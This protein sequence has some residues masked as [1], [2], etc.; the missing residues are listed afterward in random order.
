MAFYQIK[1][2]G[3][4]G[5]IADIAPTDLPPNGFTDAINAR[6]TN[7]KVTKI[8]GNKLISFQ[9]E[10]QTVVPLSI[11][12]MPFD[13][14]S[15]G[16]PFNIIGTSEGLYKLDDQHWERLSR[17]IK[18]GNATSASKDIKV[19]PRLLGLSFASN[20]VTVKQGQ[21]VTL[22]ASPVPADV[23][24]ATVKWSA[25]NQSFGTLTV[26][27]D[28]NFQA[29]FAA[30]Q[31]LG[32]VTIYIMSDDELYSDYVAL[33][34]VQNVDKMSMNKE[35]ATII[36]N[37]TET[38]TVTMNPPV[39]PLP[40]L[41]W[42]SSDT[43]VATVVVN[44]SN[45]LQATV[46]THRIGGCVISCFITDSPST[47]ATCNVTVKSGVDYIVLDHYAFTTTQNVTTDKIIATIVPSTAPNKKVTWTVPTGG[48]LVT[49]TPSTDTLTASLTYSGQGVVTVRATAQDGGVAIAECTITINATPPAPR[50]NDYIEDSIDMQVLSLDLAS[51]AAPALLAVT[52]VEIIADTTELDVTQSTTL[53]AKVLPTPTPSDHLIYQW[54]ITTNGIVTHGVSNEDEYTIQG[55]NPGNVTVN[56]SVWS[57]VQEGY[58]VTPANTWWNS[59]VANCAV[60]NI[61]THTPMVKEFNSESFIT[62]PGWGDQTLVDQDGN[63]YIQNFTWTCERVRAFNNRLFALNM[64]EKAQSGIDT[65]YPLRIRWSNFAT[66]NHAPTLWDD[67]A[68]LRDPED[69]NDAEGTLKALINGYAGYIDLADSNGNLIDML[70][71]KD[72]LFIYTEFETYMGTP[73]MNAY[74]PMTFKKLFNDS[75]ILAPG[76]VVEM[77]MGHFVVTQNDILLHNGASKKSIAA[78]RVRNKIIQEIMSVNP[79]ATRVHLHQ[80][81]NEVWIIYVAPGSVKNSW[82]CNKAAIWNFEFDTWTFADIPSAY[83][84]S[85]IDPPT[86]DK[87]AIWSDFAAGGKKPMKWNSPEAAKTRW[88]NNFSN[89]HKR[90]TVVGSE[91]R[92]LWQVDEGSLHH[93]WVASKTDATQFNIVESPLKMVLT[94]QGIDF[95]N[96][97]NDWNQKHINTFHPQ[98]GGTGTLSFVAGGSQYTN[99]MGHQHSYRP[100]IVGKSRN[101][102]VRLNHPYLYYQ[103]VDED[104]TSKASINGMTIDFEIGGRR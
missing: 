12:P 22:T 62:L 4:L 80:D 93:A 74:Q 28:N 70:P 102:S 52:S 79:L 37:Q 42:V 81:K 87:S 71:L 26:D 68:D 100:F 56:L 14:F 104:I 46:T 17:W 43:T 91:M 31:T 82:Y 97:T 101:V 54:T 2:L 9:D 50:Q 72:Y 65:H 5:V 25:S 51:P 39:T 8:G 60:A 30:G 20:S 96:I 10:D 57:A 36:T 53:K 67:F 69:N 95:D 32:D 94:R 75:G 24:N 29:T 15:A 1:N 45:H 55:M 86:L 3:E 58:T 6:F 92:G 7:G 19:F 83:C 16:L 98:V 23:R 76:C 90:I 27:P 44:P 21:T 66:E 49:V 88:Q 103:I 78:S 35:T 89:F 48:N 11:L 38:F 59:I 64:T 18:S 13:A 40:A 47:R 61:K 99:E 41:T 73:T 63:W 77:E 85:L 33:T 84:V 34:V